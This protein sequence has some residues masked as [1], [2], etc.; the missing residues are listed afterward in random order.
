MLT[1]A[2]DEE[3]VKRI[4]RD[5]FGNPLPGH[6]LPPPPKLGDFAGKLAEGGG[7]CGG[8]SVTGTA[9][10]PTGLEPQ[11]ADV[12][13]GDGQRMWGESERKAGKGGAV[14]RGVRE[15]GGGGGWSHDE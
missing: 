5:Q 8:G 4:P 12:G 1:Y 11:R 3:Q 13:G 9:F 14:A 15:Q 2:D 7:G 6:V 10:I